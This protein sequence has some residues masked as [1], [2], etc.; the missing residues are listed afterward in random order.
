MDPYQIGKNYYARFS[1]LRRQFT[2]SLRTSN[3]KV[4]NKICEQ[5]Q[6]GLERGAFD[7]FE[8]SSEGERILRLLIARPGLRVEEAIEEIHSSTKRKALKDAIAEYLENCK[9]EHA[10]SNYKVVSFGMVGH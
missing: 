4:A 2:F 3:K 5:I 6:I 7:S 9:T 10:V 1:F 8:Q